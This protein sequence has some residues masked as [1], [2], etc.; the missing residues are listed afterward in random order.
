MNAVTI[1][2]GAA[3]KVAEA[4]VKSGFWKGANEHAVRLMCYLAEAEGQHPAIVYRDYHLMNGKPSKKAEAMLADFAKAGGK[5]EWHALDDECADATFSHSSGSVRIMWTIQRA[6]QAGLNSPMWK[7]YPRQM[8]RSRCVSEG[9]RSVFPS[10]TSGLYEESEVADIAAE[11]APEAVEG[12]SGGDSQREVSPA[13]VKNWR[14]PDS[15]YNCKTALH[16]GLTVHQAEL[17]RLGD[18]G[19]IDDLEAY[20]TSAEYQEFLKIAGE[21]APH[22]L[23]GG[24]PAP[25]EFVGCFA[26]ETRARDLIMLR[27]NTPADQEKENA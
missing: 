12:R 23:E 15:I 27:G 11:S 26:L 18:E 10:A 24:E 6:K 8:L 14:E 3:E 9:V 1:Q 21:H 20:L 17:R 22:Y 2:P 16:R 7:K 4:I 5:V 25:E 13:A 19:V